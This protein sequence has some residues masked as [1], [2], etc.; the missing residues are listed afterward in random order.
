MGASVDDACHDKT[1]NS[2]FSLSTS[3][4]MNVDT[5]SRRICPP[6]RSC[7]KAGL[8]KDEMYFFRLLLKYMVIMQGT[9]EV[10]HQLLGVANC[11]SILIWPEESNFVAR[12]R[13]LQREGD[14]LLGSAKP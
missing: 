8:R 14:T 12:G 10:M 2:K 6:G 7:S 9:H 1:H 4:R 5:V 3:S 11:I 13:L